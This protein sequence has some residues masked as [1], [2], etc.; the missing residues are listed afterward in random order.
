[1][2][3]KLPVDGGACGREFCIRHGSFVQHEERGLLQDVDSL[4]GRIV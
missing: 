4:I 3:L 2:K 1:M